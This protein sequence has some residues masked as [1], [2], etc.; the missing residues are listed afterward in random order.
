MGTW[1]FRRKRRGEETSDSADSEFF[2]EESISDP[3]MALVREGI[4]NSLDAGREGESVNVRIKI[5]D[6]ESDP[7]VEEL[8]PLLEGLWKHLKADRN[9][10]RNDRLPERNE[11]FS[12]LSFED[13]G[14]TGLEGDTTQ[15]FDPKEGGNPFYYFFRGQGQTDKK[16][17]ELGSWGVGKLALFRASRIHTVYGF[18]VRASDQKRLLMGKASLKHHWVG[19]EY[20]HTGHY[21]IPPDNEDELAMPI[22]ERTEIDRF[23]EVF[24]LQREKQPGLSLVV[25]WPDPEIDERS[26]M[27]AV[28]QDYFFPIIEG[29]LEVQVEGPSSHSTLRAD[30]ILETVERV[31]EELEQ[32]LIPLLELAEWRKNLSE[33]ERT[34]LNMPDSNRRWQWSKELIPD[35]AMKALKESFQQHEKLAI[36]VPVT[37]RPEGNS[38]RESY[39]DVYL[40][41][42]PHLG[43]MRPTF[44]RDGIMVPEVKGLTTRG[45]AAL[46]VATDRPMVNFLRA[47]ENPAHTD[48]QREGGNFKGKYKSG[49]TDL[50]FVKRSA[51]ELVRMIAESEHEADP[52]LLIDFFSLPVPAEEKGVE[53][54]GEEKAEEGEKAENE[55][56]PDIPP[57]KPGLFRISEVQ[58]GVRISP[59]EQPAD[60]G[61]LFK[62]KIA[63]DTRRGNPLKKYETM[64]FELDKGSISISQDGLCVTDITGNQLIARIK[65]KDFNLAIRGFDEHRDLYVKVDRKEDQNARTAL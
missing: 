44:V 7:S 25:P 65:N 32:E 30:N 13:F 38:T 3:G 24:D 40:E 49:A 19:D 56:T 36:R 8:R 27:K 64:D 52:T 41:R 6:G 29:E 57:P 54:I 11:A 53:D 46:V 31:D 34:I 51:G 42:N 18:T 9:G 4:Q 17:S 43:R 37:I 15:A 60:L 55:E 12:F 22:K 2:A 26:L 59:G 21:A 47:A 61:D 33:G 28:L 1:Y 14:T 45:V 58:G 5:S 48:W 23:R 10:L 39:F 63:Y 35:D 50:K 20:Y 62:V 16:E